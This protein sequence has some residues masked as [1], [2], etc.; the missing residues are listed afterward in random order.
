MLSHSSS[1]FLSA[2]DEHPPR[3]GFSLR[4]RALKYNAW[5]ASRQYRSPI[6]SDSAD[7]SDNEMTT[8]PA[9]PRLMDVDDFGEDDSSSDFD[10]VF[11]GREPST[12]SL[13]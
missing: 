5:K 6:L 7:I 13:F 10:S 8:V 9:S 1:L 2:G 12:G 11:E 3:N 4:G